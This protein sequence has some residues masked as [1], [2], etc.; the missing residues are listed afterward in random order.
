MSE[1]TGVTCTL[2][3]T[4]PAH[5]ATP[6][7][8]QQFRSPRMQKLLSQNEPPLEMERSNTIHEIITSSTI[9]VSLLDER[10]LESQRILDTLINERE[11]VRLCINDARTLLHPFRTI[12]DDILR[13][14]FSWCVYGLGGYYVLSS[15]SP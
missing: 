8:V 5:P 15:W 14:V 7:V 11:Q 6:S 4:L 12:N 3:G 10:I 1:S 13:E 9:A 2:C